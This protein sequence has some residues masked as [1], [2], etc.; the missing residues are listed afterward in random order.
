VPQHEREAANPRDVVEQP[1]LSREGRGVVPGATQVETRAEGVAAAD[2]RDD[3][4]RVVASR[5][6]D[7]GDEPPGELVGEGVLLLGRSSTIVRT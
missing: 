2:D 5:R 4:D 6:L 1:A 3:P 7:R